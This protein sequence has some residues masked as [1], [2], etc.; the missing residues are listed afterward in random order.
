MSVLVARQRSGTGALGS[1]LDQHPSLEY[2]GEIFHP[3]NFEKEKNYFTFLR[4]IVAEQP[5]RT[6]P[7]RNH[8]NLMEFV[9]R[10]SP[11][12]NNCMVDIK[13]S[14]L[15]HLSSTWNSPLAPPLGAEFRS[16]QPHPHS[17]SGTGQSGRAVCIRPLG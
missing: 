13:Y 16:R 15:H 11:Y 2:I 6:H 17:T 1:V 9:A 3:G 7:D 14:S 10:Q 4:N 12:G 8:E 5:D